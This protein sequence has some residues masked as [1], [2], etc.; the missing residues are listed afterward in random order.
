VKESEWPPSRFGCIISWER[1][2]GSYWIKGSASSVTRLEVVQKRKIL[3]RK[4]IN[5]LWT[6]KLSSKLPLFINNIRSIT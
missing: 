1:I 4:E 2:T 3:A 5:Y 6:I